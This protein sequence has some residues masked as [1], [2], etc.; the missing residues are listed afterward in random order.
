MVAEP[1]GD[2]V[3]VSVEDEGTGIPSELQAKVFERF[4]QVDQSST[5][6][7]GGLGL[8]L[9]ICRRF[10]EA[11]GAELWLDR[12]DQRG[13]KFCIRIPVSEVPDPG[14]VDDDQAD[15]KAKDPQSSR[16]RVGVPAT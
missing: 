11:M 5:R 7:V 6:F 9:Y 1:A 14:S 15:A 12:S 13:S 4:Y 10:A 8:G 16:P 3:D 2:R